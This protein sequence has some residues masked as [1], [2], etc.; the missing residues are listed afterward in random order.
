MSG[1]MDFKQKI[2]ACLKSTEDFRNNNKSVREELLKKNKETTTIFLDTIEGFLTSKDASTEARF[3]SL[4]FLKLT[5]ESRNHELLSQLAHRKT[6]LRSLEEQATFDKDKEFPERGSTFFNSN[7]AE[8]EKHSGTNYLALLLE[9]IKYWNQKYADDKR[10]YPF[11]DLYRRLVEEHKVPFQS[12]YHF[13][14]SKEHKTK[15]E[16]ADDVS[17]PIY[18]A[19]DPMNLRSSKPQPQLHLQTNDKDSEDVKNAKQKIN[20]LKSVFQQLMEFYDVHKSESHEVEATISVYYENLAEIHKPFE[21]IVTILLASHDPQKEEIVLHVILQYHEKALELAQNFKKYRD[22]E[23]TFTEHRQKARDILKSE[24]DASLV[25]TKDISSQQKVISNRETFGFVDDMD[26]KLIVSENFSNSSVG[27]RPPQKTQTNLKE[28]KIVGKNE[29]TLDEIQ[30]QQKKLKEQQILEETRERKRGLREKSKH[31][32]ES[33]ITTQSLEKHSQES[34][35]IPFSVDSI[36]RDTADAKKNENTQS[37]TK[38]P[39]ASRNRETKKET[40]LKDSIKKGDDS[41][42]EVFLQLDLSKKSEEL[43]QKEKNPKS[44]GPIKKDGNFHTR[45]ESKKPELN[46][47]IESRISQGGQDTKKAEVRFLEPTLVDQPS[48]EFSKVTSRRPP[49]SDENVDGKETTVTTNAVSVVQKAGS[50]NDDR[51]GLIQSTVLRKAVYSPTILNLEKEASKP[52][53]T[54]NQ[55]C[56]D[57]RREEKLLKLQKI[58]SLEEDKKSMTAQPLKSKYADLQTSEEKEKQQKEMF[59]Q[60]LKSSQSTS[61]MR[62][63]G[64]PKSMERSL[65]LILGQTTDLK[66]IQEGIKRS[67]ATSQKKLPKTLLEDFLANKDILS[68]FEQEL[69]LLRNENQA[70]RSSTTIVGSDSS[71]DNHKSI[72]SELQKQIADFKVEIDLLKKQ[73]EELEIAASRQNGPT[74][75]ALRKRLQEL[76]AENKT[77]KK[78][79]ETDPKNAKAHFEETQILNDKIKK[80]SQENEQLVN[81]MNQLKRENQSLQSQVIEFEN[82][83][84]SSKVNSRWD[85]PE[86]QSETRK[87]GFRKQV[88]PRENYQFNWI[89]KNRS[90]DDKIFWNGL[91]EQLS[92]TEPLKNIASQRIMTSEKQERFQ[93]ESRMRDSVDIIDSSDPSNKRDEFVSLKTHNVEIGKKEAENNRFENDWN[94]GR[95]GSNAYQQHNNSNISQ[96]SSDPNDRYETPNEELSGAEELFETITKEQAPLKHHFF[97]KE[98]GNHLKSGSN[99]EGQ[100]PHHI[101]TSLRWMPDG[102][103]ET[104]QEETRNLVELYDP[105]GYDY[106]WVQ[107][108]SKKSNKLSK[109]GQR[110]NPFESEPEFNEKVK[111]TLVSSNLSIFQELNN[112]LQSGTSSQTLHHF[113]MACLKNKCPIFENN[114]LQIGASTS[115]V[116]DYSTRKHQLK[117]ALFFNNKT[118][119]SIT[120]LTTSITGGF[121][122]ARAAKPERIESTITTSKQVKQILLVS[123]RTVPISCFKL[124]CTASCGKQQLNFEMYLPTTMN[125][126]MEFKYVEADE[127]NSKWKTFSSN[128]L[129]SEEIYIDPTIIRNAH[130]FKKYF[131]YLVDIEPEDEFDFIRGNKSI[132]LGGVFDLKEPGSEYVLRIHYLPSQATVFQIATSPENVEYAKFIIQNLVFLFQKS[133]E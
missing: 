126:F 92:P 104:E 50:Q 47:V 10:N 51:T 86:R 56:E 97:G 2:L 84:G 95:S 133:R 38:Q 61:S 5:T 90:P 117:L 55:E 100:Q 28:D 11:G 14:K 124:K 123:F 91:K 109:E 105:K 59:S 35:A 18:K 78:K 68:K 42:K 29:S 96:V 21:E 4:F 132:K 85:E 83:L 9:I 121:N 108:L 8:K 31:D 72:V 34:K 33:N 69:H 13:Y 131:A 116:Q 112:H 111:G 32:E 45:E 37:K 70:L 114:E 87:A 22:K 27:T 129:K 17:S 98:A 67:F 64:D 15:D 62:F 63:S 113:K 94:K 39:E 110:R 46:L 66:K 25:S 88:S 81:S 49:V 54:K 58:K 93:R 71:Q 41:Q 44:E 77:L 57:P 99:T 43:A 118:E 79:L 60:T 127:L 106:E 48:P 125:K 53:E 24:V 82:H 65:K 12:N 115:I 102:V 36:A 73:N 119:G 26:P 120:D 52:A 30:E 1:N 101:F 103:G 80:L 89:E 40:L 122:L 19:A 23:I 128:T 16:I 107:K 7:P 130:D 20:S 76:E 6:L 3:Y 74:Y 75:D